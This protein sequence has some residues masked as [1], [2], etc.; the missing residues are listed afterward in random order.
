MATIRELN[1]MC[2]KKGGDALA[3]SNIIWRPLSMLG[4]WFCIRLGIN[5]TG[6]T[7]LSLVAGLA[8]ALCFVDRCPAFMIAGVA[9]LFVNTY[10]DHVDG[11]LARY[12]R[13]VHHAPV[14]P[15]GGFFDLLVHHYVRPLGHFCMGYGL[16]VAYGNHAYSMLGFWAGF[17][18]MG[19]AYSTAVSILFVDAVKNP[20]LM[21]SEGVRQLALLRDV[22]RPEENQSAFRLLM[23]RARHLK[24]SV[25]MAYEWILIPVVVIDVLR[26]E[27][28]VLFGVRV[29]AMIVYLS[30]VAALG[31]IQACAGSVFIY[32][33]LK[34]VRQ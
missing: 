10:L 31:I 8:G 29:N 22:P 23:H 26:P 9:L 25:I 12:E 4:V 17:A 20:A 11:G 19:F 24:T 18:H 14:T 5:S 32:R 30:V 16:A 28:W 7:A 15:A 3:L 1:D 21:Q 6:A 27:A 34:T 33:V 13:V 2:R